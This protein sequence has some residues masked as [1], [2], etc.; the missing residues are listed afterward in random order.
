MAYAP[1]YICKK[2][3]AYKAWNYDT[4]PFPA[5]LEYGKNLYEK[6]GL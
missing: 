1:K 3:P 4:T 5:V 6:K 2:I